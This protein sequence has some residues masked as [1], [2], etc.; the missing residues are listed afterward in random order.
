MITHVHSFLHAGCRGYTR[1]EVV[2]DF[3]TERYSRKSHPNPDI[4]AL[5]DREWTQ[6]LASSS[7]CPGTTTPVLFNKSKF[8]LAAWTPTPESL[9]LHVGLTDYKTYQSIH[10]HARLRQA[11]EERGESYLSMKLGVSG[12]VLTSDQELVLLRRSS[13]V[14]IHAQR[15]DMPGGHP[16]PDE[17]HHHLRMSSDL[18]QIQIFQSIVR[19]IE[20]EVNVPESKLGPPVLLGVISQLSAKTP[21]LGF[22]IPCRATR[23][24]VCRYYAQGPKEG[25]ESQELVFV[26]QD[27]VRS[28]VRAHASDC[29]PAALGCIELWQHYHSLYPENP[30]GY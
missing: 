1:D 9:T 13:C 26:P 30:M 18:I 23:A 12:I 2:I 7:S 22:F 28:W 15:L 6:R 17:I 24:T 27:E 16:E 29:T 11:L 5:I 20:E 14:G 25:F 10:T 19:E 8:R 4:E 21:T 3:S